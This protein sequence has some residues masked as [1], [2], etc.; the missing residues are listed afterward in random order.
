MSKCMHESAIVISDLDGFSLLRC[1]WECGKDLIQ[2]NLGNHCVK[3]LTP[4]DIIQLL[5]DA[6][7]LQALEAFGVDN[8]QGYDA[9]MEYLEEL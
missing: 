9:A 1:T 8:W 5:E 7:K 2:L 3:Y 4:E 6:K